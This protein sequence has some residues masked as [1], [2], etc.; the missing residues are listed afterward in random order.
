[1]RRQPEILAAA[2]NA[3]LVLLLPVL[4]AIALWAGLG[5]AKYRTIVNPL[6]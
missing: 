2:V 5:V 4:L 1:M 6:Q 3:V